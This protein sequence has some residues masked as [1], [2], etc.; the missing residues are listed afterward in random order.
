MSTVLYT[1][2]SNLKIYEISDI[3]PG[4]YQKVN[5]FVN[6]IEALTL[7]NDQTYSK[8]KTWT[9]LFY[10]N[11]NDVLILLMH[12]HVYMLKL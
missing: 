4:L 8:Q 1:N 3:P 6:T 7:G 10:N 9:S 12:I 5:L 11:L 2:C